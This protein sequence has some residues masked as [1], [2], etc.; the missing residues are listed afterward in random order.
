MHVFTRSERF[1]RA[2]APKMESYVWAVI[3]T[4]AKQSTGSY[5]DFEL[6]VGGRKTTASAS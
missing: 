3:I 2:K 4:K 1:V 6:Q 5:T